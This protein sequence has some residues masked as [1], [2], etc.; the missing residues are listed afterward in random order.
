MYIPRANQETRLPVLHEL[1]RA[2]PLAALVTMT[3]GGLF[4]SHIPLVL[5]AEAAPFGVLRGHLARANA[6]WQEI[7]RS[8]EALAIFSGPGHAISASWY[9]STQETG[10]NVPTWNYVTVHAYGPVEV[11][12]DPAWLMEHL[13]QLTQE[14]EAPN[15]EPWKIED[16]PPAYIENMLRGIVGIELRV[17]RIEG[18]WKASQN[19]DERDRLGV[20]RGLEA[21]NTP[22]SLAMRDIVVER[23]RAFS[24]SL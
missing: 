3:S 14:S 19:R 20:V 16:A 12:E 9:P 10:E 7:D 8:V 13:H 2:E 21:L 1:I 4:A 6:Q 23:P 18:K 22:A 17:S 5:D 11:I 15:P 24:Q